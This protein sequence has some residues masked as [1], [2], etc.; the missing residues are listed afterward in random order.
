MALDDRAQPARRSC[1]IGLAGLA[2]PLL[3]TP[4]RAHAILIASQPQP[5]ATMRAGALAIRLSFNS[6]I[7]ANRSRL[8]LTG[9]EGAETQSGVTAI[10]AVTL[11]ATMNAPSPGAWRLR[12]QVLAVD[13]HITRGDVEFR[14]AS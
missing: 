7:D 11:T 5:G 6:R 8:T 4:A 12:W 2:L 14:V 9:P 3:A 10:D 13:G 1:L